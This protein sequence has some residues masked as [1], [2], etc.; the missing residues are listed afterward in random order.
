[1][2]SAMASAPLFTKCVGEFICA[3]RITV[4]AWAAVD[5]KAVLAKRAIVSLVIG[6][7]RIRIA[8]VKTSFHI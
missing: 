5:A 6:S 7:S 8:H 4:S 3:K 2:P 1:M